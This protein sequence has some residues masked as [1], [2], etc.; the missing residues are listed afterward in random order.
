MTAADVSST[1][2]IPVDLLAA[3]GWRDATGAEV[4][5]A[6]G[7]Y[8]HR[9]ADLGGIIIPLRDPRTG[10]HLG[11]WARLNDPPTGG[12][13][14]L[15][16]QGGRWLY[17][18]P[19][20]TDY[21]YDVSVPVVFAE[22]PKSALAL[23]ALAQRCGRRLVAIATGGCWGWRRTVTH[24][25]Q[26]D[27]TLAGV[28]G[29]S[30]SLDWIAWTGRDAIIALDGD[31]RA[32]P[33]V[34]AALRSLAYEL[35][36]RGASVRVAAIPPAAGAK[37][38][39][40]DVIEHCGDE[41]VL[42]MLDAARPRADCAVAAAEAA[43]VA[44]EADRKADPLPAIAA[45]AAVDDTSRRELLVGRLVALRLPGVTRELATRRIAAERAEAD[46]AR[47]AAAA[48]ARRGKL[49]GLRV[50][51][52]ALLDALAA[53]LRD[54]VIESAAQAD[55]EALWLLHTYALGAADYT[56]YLHITA[57]EKRC[58]KSRLLEVLELLAA[59][60][61]RCD[62]TTAAAL[63]RSVERD[64]PTLLLDEW[65]AARG[66]SDEY[67]EAMR[68]LLNSGFRRGG[69]YRMCVGE[70][71]EPHDFPTFC[72]KSL[73]GIGR[74]PDTVADRS[75][76][77][78]LRR[79]S[80]H[81]RVRQFRRRDAEPQAAYLRE[82]AEAW[83]MQAV[84]RLRDH[85]P[86]MPPQ[87][88]DRQQDIC[89]P[90]FA[91]ADL[92]GGDWPERAR[93]A[94]VEVC[95]GEAAADE[96]IGAKLLADARAVFAE[97]GADRLASKDLAEAL[98]EMEDRPWAEWGRA[99]K[100]ITAPQVARQL[101]RFGIIPRNLREGGAVAKGYLRADFAEAWDRYLAPALPPDDP[102][103]PVPPIPNRYTATRPVN[104]G[105]SG[106][107]NAA[108]E[109]GCSGTKNGV[110]NN[111]HAG[112]SGVAVSQAEIG[113]GVTQGALFAT[114]PPPPKAEGLTW[115]E[116]IARARAEGRLPAE[117]EAPARKDVEL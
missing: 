67:A 94:L 44:L 54:Y 85:R 34:S 86:A 117:P 113:P 103:S 60:A 112:R 53:T 66:S 93:R 95:S 109:G 63:L 7:Y 80:P 57:P 83:A 17:V 27:G 47:Q 2:R 48:A 38:G 9:D 108:T 72:A 32:N 43:I 21:L 51:G 1:L 91:I 115:A 16:P 111:N 116:S 107:F 52:A 49:L 62:R 96:S 35:A 73:A 45:L 92:V 104:T 106:D 68:G 90:L 14:Y 46:A 59:R 20:P 78:A 18:P 97:R 5:E 42:A 65:D 98:G 6:L 71:R 100:P 23:V 74:L 102:P 69:A 28:T 37:A 33:S 99:Q 76:V 24:E 4:R 3:A 36:G 26:P 19:V 89:E 114:P 64:S 39:P 22:G 82:Q 79:K 105:E 8:G 56:P 15:Q 58:G 101:G 29:P 70:D 40:D 87:L 81:E 25:R 88:N 77:I 12:G 10:E 61:W 11:D 50:D 84:G 13:K 41:A 110:S 55:V 30:P 75:I 31:A